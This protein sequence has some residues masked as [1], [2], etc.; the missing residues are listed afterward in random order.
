MMKG[1]IDIHEVIKEIG[2]NRTSREDEQ[3]L[4]DALGKDTHEIIL[5]VVRNSWTLTYD[6]PEDYRKGRC[7]CGNLTNNAGPE[8]EV[9]FH[10]SRKSEIEEVNTGE[11][12]RLNVRYSKFDNLYRRTSFIEAPEDID[13]PITRVVT[14]ENPQK[15]PIAPSSTHHYLANI[16][17]IAYADGNLCPEEDA[18]L[19]TI[20]TSLGANIQDMDL[21]L[22]IASKEGFQGKIVGTFSEQVRNLEDM[23]RI[24]MADGKVHENENQWIS[25]FA[26]LIGLD[27]PQMDKLYQNLDSS[28]QS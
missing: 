7:I 16:L 11:R 19:D 6:V 2:A 18:V 23:M 5:Y 28:I 25:Y 4:D 26:G 10:N 12:L 1:T 8:V 14:Q 15:Q 3:K 22:Q 21:A 27:Q 9:M 13:N 24:C 20:L 17:T